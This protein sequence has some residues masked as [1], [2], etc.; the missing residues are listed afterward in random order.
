MDIMLVK[1][2]VH[3][4][5]FRDSGRYYSLPSVK[6]MNPAATTKLFTAD[7]VEMNFK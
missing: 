3:S 1:F 6:S 2:V 4:T 5:K 7:R